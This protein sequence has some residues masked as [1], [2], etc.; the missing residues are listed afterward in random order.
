M[1]LSEELTRL[2]T[3]LWRVTNDQQRGATLT[4][5]EYLVLARLS[6]EGAMRA[7]D[8]A[9]AEGLDPSTLSRRVA[10]LV[11]RRLVTREAEATD[12]R[13]HQLRLTDAGRAQFMAEQQRRVG[14]V[15][16]AVAHW[17]EPDRTR[18][19]RLL[20]DLNDSLQRKA[21]S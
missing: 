6:R 4:R 19:V 11:E 20:H 16:D 18:L 3:L 8:L 2:F 10:A 5:L 15:A 13:A 7:R 14:L 21:T 12:R 1:Q 9:Q 17:S